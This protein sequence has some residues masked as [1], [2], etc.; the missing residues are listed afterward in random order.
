[1][2]GKDI[3]LSDMYSLNIDKLNEF[4]CLKESEIEQDWNDHSSSDEDS[5]TEDEAESPDA[6]GVLAEIHEIS[7]KIDTLD[8]SPKVVRENESLKNY[9]SRTISYWVPEA[10]QYNSSQA[11]KS[12]RRDAF[13]LAHSFY[14]RQHAM[15]VPTM[16]K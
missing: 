6:D 2:N 10:L 1:M 15:K 14:N 7:E 4:T 9:Y 16:R 3:T 5:E 11:G 12:L 8:V 13:Q